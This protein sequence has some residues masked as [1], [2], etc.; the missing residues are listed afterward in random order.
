MAGPAPDPQPYDLV[1]HNAELIATVDDDRR[2]IPGG[3]IAVRDGLIATTGTG[4][5]PEAAERV[6][7]GLVTVFG[8]FIARHDPNG[9]DRAMLGNHFRQRDG[10]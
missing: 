6:V 2:E 10:Q 9:F 1:I 4:Q 7:I 5:P 3:W 8:A